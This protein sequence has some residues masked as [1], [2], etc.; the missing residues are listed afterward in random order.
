M[1]LPSLYTPSSPEEIIGSAGQIVS[2]AFRRFGPPAHARKE[3]PM[4]P[5]VSVSIAFRRFGPPAQRPELQSQGI[6]LGVSIAFRR[7]GPPARQ[8][9]SA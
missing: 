5:G 3:P 2:I 1:K 4:V 9:Y 6:G 7:F 8:E